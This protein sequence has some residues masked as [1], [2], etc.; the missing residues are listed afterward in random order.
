MKE[1]TLDKKKAVVDEIRA[2]I[3]NA[4]SV[5][6]VEYAGINVQ[7]IT[8]LRAKF[9]EAK[10]NYK[11]YKNTMVR[12]AFHD[13]GVEDFDDLLNGPN[14]FI[15]SK[16]DMVSGPKIADEFIKDH[17]DQLKIKAGYLEG[18]AIDQAKVVALSKLPTKEVLISM[19]LRGL[20]GPIAGLAQV[21]KATLSSLV[22]GLNAVKEKKE[23][24]AA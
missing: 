19:L 5:V 7:D 21:G 2:E 16:E 11:V 4:Q 15:F 18:K 22:Y 12:R 9:R 17:E 14:A 3:E 23:Q 24:E 20:Q 1:A 13:L 6:I 10:V 8:D